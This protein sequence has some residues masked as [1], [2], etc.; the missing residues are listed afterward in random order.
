MLAAG[1]VTGIGGG[2]APL[3]ADAGFMEV[4]GAKL[5]GAALKLV[6]LN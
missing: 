1:W 4:G 6:G 2:N 5:S 3:K